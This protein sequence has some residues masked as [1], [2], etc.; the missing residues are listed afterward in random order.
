M[1]PEARDVPPPCPYII[2]HQSFSD[3]ISRGQHNQLQKTGITSMK[4][5]T[6]NPDDEGAEIIS[7]SQARRVRESDV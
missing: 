4:R 5:V 3:K 7:S 6:G 1:R 2:L